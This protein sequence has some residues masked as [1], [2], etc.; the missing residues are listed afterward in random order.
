M[1][2]FLAPDTADMI[3]HAAERGYS[4]LLN[5]T[6]VGLK[7]EDW[8]KIKDINYRELHIHLFSYDEMIGVKIPV[9]T[10]E[11]EGRKIKRLLVK[12]IMIC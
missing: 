2:P 4:I 6:L 9:E 1:E 10:Y 12:T 8:M 3:L 5:T 11:H 7:K